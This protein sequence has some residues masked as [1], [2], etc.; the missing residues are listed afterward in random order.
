[1]CCSLKTLK[2]DILEY[3]LTWRQGHHRGHRVRV[4]LLGWSPIQYDW[5]PYKRETW[6]QRQVA[7]RAPW[8]RGGR[9]WGDASASQG[10]TKDGQQTTQGWR[11][12]WNRS[13]LVVSERTSPVQTWIW[14]L[15][16]G[17]M[18]DDMF[19]LIKSLNLCCF[20]VA[21][22]ENESLKCMPNNWW[23]QKGRS[24]IWNAM[25]GLSLPGNQLRVNVYG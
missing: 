20:V 15:A 11:E 25:H 5:Y 18:R 2:F 13:A 16:D 9:D 21:A 17:T 7:H 22:Q 23:L 1:M 19:L 24:H 3:D 8:E 14:I 10:T 12:A 4:R 6:M